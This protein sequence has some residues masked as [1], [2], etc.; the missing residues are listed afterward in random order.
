MEEPARQWGLLKILNSVAVSLVQRGHGNKVTSPGAWGIWPQSLHSIPRLR[1][2]LN[3]SIGG[4]GLN[5]S[6]CNGFDAGCGAVATTTA[7]AC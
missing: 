6:I 2:G 4:V 7:P 5:E 1:G 3:P